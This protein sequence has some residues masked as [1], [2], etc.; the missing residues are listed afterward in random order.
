VRPPLSD[1]HDLSPLRDAPDP[2]ISERMLDRLLAVREFKRLLDGDC[3]IL[4]WVEGPVAEAADLRGVQDFL[5]DLMD[6]ESAAFALMA[7]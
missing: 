6:D 4:G 2:Y 3:S 7:R 5:L 1:I